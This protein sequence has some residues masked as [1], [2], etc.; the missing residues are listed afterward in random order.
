MTLLF[1]FNQSHAKWFDTL[2]CIANILLKKNQSPIDI[3][4]TKALHKNSELILEPDP[5][6]N[7]SFTVEKNERE[8]TRMLAEKIL[9][10][11]V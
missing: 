11:E 3:D 1:Y 6:G 5:I 4:E 2:Q 9:L 7:Y 8:G 10:Y